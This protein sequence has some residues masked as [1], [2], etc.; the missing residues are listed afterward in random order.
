M[1]QIGMP[2]K[3]LTA[4]WQKQLRLKGL[5]A[6]VLLPDGLKEALGMGLG[7]HLV[8]GKAEAGRTVIREAVTTGIVNER[9][10][11]GA[12]VRQGDPDAAHETMGLAMEV[13]RIAVDGLLT[14]SGK[15]KRLEGEGLPS[16]NTTEECKN[17]GMQSEMANR[18]P[19]SPAV[20]KP[21]RSRPTGLP[22]FQ[23]GGQECLEAA[24]NFLTILGERRIVEFQC[25]IAQFIE[26]ASLLTPQA[27]MTLCQKIG[28]VRSIDQ[29]RIVQDPSH[30]TFCRHAAGTPPGLATT[31]SGR[32]ASEK[33]SSTS[34]RWGL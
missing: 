21:R 2:Y 26:T 32:N 19:I 18:R 23:L 27:K 24:D 29:W 7:S 13:D 15:V 20:L 11:V 31:A 25:A 28:K 6:H 10:T 22:L 5:S 4:A 14:T 12:H 1:E 17:A 8:R 3:N 33:F 16:I 9:S 34:E 30:G